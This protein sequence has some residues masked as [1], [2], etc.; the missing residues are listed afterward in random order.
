MKRELE[1]LSSLGEHVA[2][3][4]AESLIFFVGLSLLGLK[5]TSRAYCRKSGNLPLERMGGFGQH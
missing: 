2:N 3:G 4:D 5:K 1:Q